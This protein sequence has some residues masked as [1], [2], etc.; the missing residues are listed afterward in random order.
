[1]AE[2]NCLNNESQI[3]SVLSND[4]ELI[5]TLNAEG[6][7]SSNLENVIEISRNYTGLSNEDINVV[8][9]NNDFTI[10]ATLQKM[11]Y[12]SILE[13]PNVGSENKIYA[14]R[15]T[16]TL[17]IWDSETLS[18]TRL[19]GDWTEIGRINGGGA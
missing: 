18:Y 17:Y 8:V 6:Q 1:M 2:Y 12:N 14:D 3:D 19:I 15:E 16:N 10:S 9:N 4:A 13:F 11:W 5:S 7:V